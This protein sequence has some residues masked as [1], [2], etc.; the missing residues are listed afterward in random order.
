MNQGLGPLNLEHH[1]TNLNQTS[2]GTPLV[3]R[4]KTAARST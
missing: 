3:I 2:T 4:I 1:L